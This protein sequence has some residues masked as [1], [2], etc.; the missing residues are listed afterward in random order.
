MAKRKTYKECRNEGYDRG[1]RDVFEAIMMNDYI[2][3]DIDDLVPVA[4]EFK[5]SEKELKGIAG[6][7]EEDDEYDEVFERVE[8]E[9]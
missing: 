8:R 4:E 7:S 6:I 1:V 2:S 3:I 5:I 9:M